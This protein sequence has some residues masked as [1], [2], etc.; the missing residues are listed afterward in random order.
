VVSSTNY[1]ENLA[2]AAKIKTELDKIESLQD[3][4]YSQP[5][6]YP[7]IDVTIDREMTGR[8]GATAEDI[9]RSLLAATSSSR[10]VVPNYWRDP[11]SGIGY[12]V[13]VE[14]PIERM[15]SSKQV[16]LVPIKNTQNGKQLLLQDIATIKDGK[17]PG[18]YDRYNMKRL[19]SIMAN[20]QGEDLGRVSTRIK[21]AIEDAGERPAGIN[22]DVRG[23]IEPMNQM[24]QGLLIG[25]GMAVLAI[26]LLLTGYFQSVRLALTVMATAPAVIAGVALMLFITNTTLNI[27]SFMG[28]IMAVGVATANA[29]LLVTFAEKARR[30]GDDPLRAALDGARHRLRPILMTS[31]AMVAGMTPMA[32]SLGEGGEQVA[33]LGRAVIGGLIAAT[34]TTLLILPAIFAIVQG[35]ASTASVS[36]DPDD[37]ESQHFDGGTI[38]KV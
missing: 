29:I 1:A 7:T 20:V 12:Q 10:F 30:R 13:Q 5:L 14:V 3:L 24:F 9:A 21:K 11:K 22:V 16:G 17:M 33:P 36:L 26:F 6:D 19:I 4:Q 25:L 27:Q 32:L 35:G 31:F 23:Q 34:M 37:P 8:G 18:A 38:A 2:F 15:N 28:A